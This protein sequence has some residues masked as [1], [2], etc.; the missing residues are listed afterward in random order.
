MRS[1]S[2]PRAL[3][4]ALLLACCTALTL[5][6][7]ALGKG[8]VDG[9][10][11]QDGFVD[12]GATQV[13]ERGLGEVAVGPDGAIFV[14]EDASGGRCTRTLCFEDA[15]LKRYGADGALTQRYLPGSAIRRTTNW[16]RIAVDDRSRPLLAWEKRGKQVL[17]RRLQ[18][19][20][21]LDHRFGKAGTVALPCDC[22][23]QSLAALPGGG[24]LVA[25]GRE[26]S[27]G[28]EYRGAVWYIAKLRSDGTADQRFG[29]G[30][31][32]RLWMP[33]RSMA[34]AAPGRRGS[35]L[36]KSSACCGEGGPNVDFVSRLSSRGRLQHRF[37]AAF[38]RSLPGIYGE[39]INHY[40][41][42]SGMEAGGDHS[43]DGFASGWHEARAFRLHENGSLDRSYG[44]RGV[45]AL[46]LGFADSAPDGRG[47][48]LVVGYYRNKGYYVRRLDRHGKVDRS[49]GNLYLPRA[50]N[51]EGLQIIPQGR[52]RAIVLAR[53][54]SFCRQECSSDPKLFRVLG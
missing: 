48:T 17:V 40:W 31:V 25:A 53:D 18:P 24:V 26:I 5:A 22:A 19:T 12:L 47:G 45:T 34:E 20:G 29:D 7:P 32:V 52:G 30:G 49:F 44:R 14:V 27:R 10:F 46:P 41:E 2:S 35:V 15:W 3:A 38:K 9:S 6:S 13:D 8:R 43:L 37:G 50:Y 28:D 33:G 39:T 11:G 54:L 42:W 4:A 1:S 23:L 51:E 16:V 21:G 36:L